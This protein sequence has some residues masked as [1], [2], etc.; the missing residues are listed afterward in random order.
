MSAGMTKSMSSGRA[1][2]SIT[3]WSRAPAADCRARKGLDFLATPRCRSGRFVEIRI[4]N[5]LHQLSSCRRIPL[6]IA[7]SRLVGLRWRR[8]LKT[9]PGCKEDDP[10]GKDNKDR[11]KQG[12][13]PP[14]SSSRCRYWNAKLHYRSE[15]SSAYQRRKASGSGGS[16][17]SRISNSFCASFFFPR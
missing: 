4:Q 6:A 10:Q 15:L 9:S 11:E 3:R 8:V 16:K 17:P 13:E 12:A 1:G 7:R 14:M 5:I 2:C